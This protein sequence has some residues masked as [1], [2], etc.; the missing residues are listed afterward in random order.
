MLGWNRTGVSIHILMRLLVHVPD[1]RGNGRKDQAGMAPWLI[2]SF[3]LMSRYL[4]MTE[5]YTGI[6]AAESTLRPNNNNVTHA[7]RSLVHCAERIKLPTMIEPFPLGAADMI[8][9]I[10]TGTPTITNSTGAGSPIR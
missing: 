6:I 8:T 9:Q 10:T 5:F 1:A 3:L 7:S 2:Q 4:D